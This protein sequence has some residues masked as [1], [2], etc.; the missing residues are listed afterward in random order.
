[1]RQKTIQMNQNLIKE[2]NGKQKEDFCEISESSNLEFI[3]EEYFAPFIEDDPSIEKYNGHTLEEYENS[4][5]PDEL[6]DRYY[7]EIF[8]K[9]YDD[10]FLLEELKLNFNHNSKH[11]FKIWFRDKFVYDFEI[12][13]D[14][15]MKYTW[16]DAFTIILINMCLRYLVHQFL[17]HRDGG[18]SPEWDRLEFFLNTVANTPFEAGLFEHIEDDFGL[19]E[20]ED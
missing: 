4:L 5:N 9:I 13:E 12:K 20:D 18:Y 7:S 11:D 16:S 8:F 17:L 3:S 1:M 6:L 2:L 14:D 10:E 19:F 15:H